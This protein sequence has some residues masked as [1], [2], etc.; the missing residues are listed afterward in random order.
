MQ[1]ITITFA[2]HDWEF[3]LQQ[4]GES[5][6]WYLFRQ[7]AMSPGRSIADVLEDPTVDPQFRQLLK[8][9]LDNET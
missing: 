3:K 2:W 9:T 6:T 5:A 4:G 8:R 1:M 7:G